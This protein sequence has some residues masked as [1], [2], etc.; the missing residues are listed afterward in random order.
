[1]KVT[2]VFLITLIALFT[3]HPLYSGQ[4]SLKGAIAYS[5]LTDGYWQIWVKD[6]T[7]GSERQL[8]FSKIDKK[9]PAWSENGKWLIYRTNNGEFFLIDKQGLNE[10]RLLAKLGYLAD[11][12]WLSDKQLLFV[13][14]R[15]DLKDD[16]DI[17]AA[18]L[19]DEGKVKVLNDEAGLQYNPDISQD[20]KKIAYVSGHKPEEHEIWVMDF[21]GKNRQ[22]LTENTYY[23]ICPRWSPNGKEIVF[24]SNRSGN[25]EIWMMNSDGSG[26]K[27]LTNLGG[28]NTTPVWSADGEK[29]VFGSNKNGSFEI[30]VMDKNGKN[31]TQ[32]TKGGQCC[33]PAWHF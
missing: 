15:S 30:W 26:Q 11:P 25:Y 18:N 3:S 33:D 6:L 20:G 4:G 16:S 22:K 21:A 14:F 7:A 19:E 24:A 8:T 32:L 5:R 13:R 31:L 9:N 2:K 27:M 17:W 1:M 28:F 12:N 10:K 23:D 29:I